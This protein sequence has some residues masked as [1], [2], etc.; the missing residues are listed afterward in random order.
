M[1]RISTI[2]IFTLAALST[3]NVS[4]QNSIKSER[5][6]LTI[7]VAGVDLTIFERYGGVPPHVH[8]F[9]GHAKY[10]THQALFEL[11]FNLPT[12]LSYGAYPEDIEP[13]FR[14]RNN[15]SVQVTF[16]LLNVGTRLVQ[17]GA[18]GLSASL[19][20]SWN[21]YV[22]EDPTR[23]QR[24][25][26]LLTAE[27]IKSSKWVKTKINTFS[28]HLPILL[29]FGQ[30]KGFFGAVGVYGDLLV[31]SHSKIKHGKKRDNEKHYNLPTALPQAGV[32]ARVG[33]QRIYLF[34]NYSLTRL[35]QNDRGPETNIL[36]IGLGLGF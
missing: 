29:E 24:T 1:K 3:W 32:T 16:N 9:S 18:V 2:I 34:G 10:R 30:R 22:F 6:N 33:Y 19:G 5:G 4:G 36:T 31:A 11:G 13:W 17:S 12:Q 28:L 21:D 35:F 15:K 25:G 7:C 26:Q 14:L 8:A 27:P 20:I 23:V